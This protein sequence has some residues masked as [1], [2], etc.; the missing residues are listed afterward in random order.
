M[1][2]LPMK[3]EGAYDK[4]TV[5][6][7]NC[8]KIQQARSRNNVL[9]LNQ[10]KINGSAS[11]GNTANQSMPEHHSTNVTMSSA[12]GSQQSVFI[13]QAARKDKPIPTLVNVAQKGQKLPLEAAGKLSVI[14]VRLG[15]N[16]KN[17]EC[18]VDVSAFLLQ[19]NKAIGDSWFVF[20]GQTKSPDGSTVFSESNDADRELITIDFGRLNH[21]VDKIVFVLTIDEAFL[22]KLNFSMIKDAYI[23]IMNKM[24]GNE[25]ASFLMD[26]YYSNV[27]SMM[28][29]EIYRHNG[30]WKFN[31]VG[32]GVSRDLEGLCELYG[33]Q[34]E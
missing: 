30:A 11:A 13:N 25:I 18:D 16:V 19:N 20:Y 24:T 3:T 6:S 21:A 9:A 33:V 10:Q 1:I 28:I 12:A 15:W 22:K 29:G 23:R 17:P 32:N 27:T 14:E 2:N 34:V 5:L 4:R 7:I 26:E 31:A 8:R